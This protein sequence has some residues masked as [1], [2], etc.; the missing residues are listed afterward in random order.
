MEVRGQNAT[1]AVATAGQNDPLRSA[2]RQ[3]AFLNNAANSTFETA[4]AEQLKNES[5]LV[6]QGK[7]ITAVL[8]TAIVTDLPGQLKARVNRDIW[9][10]DGSSVLI[11]K[12]ST[13]IGEYDS[14]IN[15]GQSRTLVAWNRVITTDLRSV[16]IGST[17]IDR[18]GRGGVG[19]QVDHHFGL[20][21]EAAFFVSIFSAI[22]NSGRS[23]SGGAGASGLQSNVLSIADQYL[24]IPPS[25]HTNQGDE[26]YVF[27]SKD[28]YL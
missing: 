3:N 21:F 23:S 10:A 24:S 17:G 8:E 1:P 9:S 25:I 16:N 22:G 6:E 2:D 15:I 12:G 11:P 26:V 19:G 4:Y 18:L 27:V 7:I 20:K 13:L 28:L 14:N 5:R